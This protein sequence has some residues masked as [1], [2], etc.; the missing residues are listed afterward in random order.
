MRQRL[1]DEVAEGAVRVDGLQRH[2][3]LLGELLPWVLL[4]VPRL[5]RLLPACCALL[6]PPAFVCAC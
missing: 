2:C 6:Q 5:L 4:A 1:S 3:A